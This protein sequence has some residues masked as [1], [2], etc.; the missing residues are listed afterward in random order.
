MLRLAVLADLPLLVAIRDGSDAGALSD[1]ALAADESL[2]RL[3]GSD[4]VMVWD[5]EN[6]IAGFAAVE[7]GAIHLLVDPARRS[8][9]VGRALL[10]W[11]CAVAKEAGHA[12]ATLALPPGGT[13]ERHYRAAGWSD[14]GWSDAG[15]SVSGGRILKKP[16]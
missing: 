9:G 12:Q 10:A 2:R 7:N 3:I 8:R 4:T 13:A 14:A 5:D 15:T 1:P 11:A 6:T 16:L